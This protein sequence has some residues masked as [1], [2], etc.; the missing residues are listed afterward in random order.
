[1]SIQ[2]LIIAFI[3]LSY[4]GV[5][6]IFRT[7]WVSILAGMEYL[8]L[9]FVIAPFY[10]EPQL[11]KPLIF[12]FLGWTGLLIGTQFKLEYLA[13]L[14]KSFYL[15]VLI[16]CAVLVGIIFA[17]ASIIFPADSALIAAVCITPFS[18]IMI[19][20][21]LQNDRYTLFFAGFLPVVSILFLFLFYCAG[22]AFLTIAKFM[23]FICVYCIISRFILTHIDESKSIDLMLIGL[24][25]LI[26]ES[27]AVIGISPLV[28][29]FFVGVYI[30]NFCPLQDIIFANLYTNEKP[31]YIM[32]LFLTGIVS[33][34]ALEWTVIAGGMFLATTALLI[35]CTC[36]KISR[37]RFPL[38]QLLTLC[39]PGAFALMLSTD[40]WLYRGAIKHSEWFSTMIVCIV[41]L[42]CISAFAKRAYDY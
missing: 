31:I 2:T 28:V 39:T 1:M 11:I 41:I 34:I 32:S 24:V 16:Y 22:A 36:L 42:Q 27:C 13:R 5:Y 21:V 20:S 4:L 8:L 3:V 37:F 15:H 29:T 12:A 23:L 30:V 6:L 18:Y 35:K 14:E 26:S 9:G 7:R 17:A 19:S 25:L 33:G 38:K 40:F 10:S